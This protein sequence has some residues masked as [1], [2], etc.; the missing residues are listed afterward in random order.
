VNKT[1]N[2]KLLVKR[3]IENDKNALDGLYHYYY[4][5]LYYFIKGF[6][7]VED[8]VD[9]VIQDVFVKLWENRNNITSV[10]TFNSWVFTVTKNEVISLFRSKIKKAEFE[11]RIRE[12]VIQTEIFTDTMLEYNEIK[13]RVDQLIEQLPEKRRQIFKL[14]REQG[15]SQKEIANQLGI[16][17]KTVE[18]HMMHAIRFMRENLK[19]SDLITLLYLAIF[20]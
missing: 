14:S 4:P 5:R 9:D 6:L 13:G 20:F 12:T 17:V 1:V 10:E 15:L 11:T 18:D 8:E 3:L 7:K 2:I 16:S 19:S